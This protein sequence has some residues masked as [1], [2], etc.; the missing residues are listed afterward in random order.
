MSR[1]QRVALDFDEQ[2]LLAI[3]QSGLTNYRLAKLAGIRQPII[4]RYLAR[5]NLGLHTRTATKLC[6]ILG[7]ELVKILPRKPGKMVDSA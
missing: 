6:R 1:K 5:T 4:D 3:K 7:L 2:L